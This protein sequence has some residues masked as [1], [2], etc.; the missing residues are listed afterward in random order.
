MRK[1]HPSIRLSSATP[2]RPSPTSPIPSSQLHPMERLDN[3]YELFDLLAKEVSF[4]S[5]RFGSR[6]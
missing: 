6:R 2:H 4:F 3:R 5:D 1:P